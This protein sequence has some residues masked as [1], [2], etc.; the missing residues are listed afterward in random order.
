MKESGY[1]TDFMRQLAKEYEHVEYNGRKADLYALGATLFF[2]LCG[3][4]PSGCPK[5]SQQTPVEWLKQHRKLPKELIALLENILGNEL[6]VKNTK[7][8][9]D[10]VTL[11]LNKIKKK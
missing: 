10:E 2:I 3:Y 11:L 1:N 6:Q 4:A 9:Y 7:E 5:E 8:F